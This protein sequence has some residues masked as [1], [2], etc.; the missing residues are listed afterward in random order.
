MTPRPAGTEPM[1][2]S[3][4]CGHR[5]VTTGTYAV[6]GT[7]LWT[8]YWQALGFSGVV[9]VPRSASTSLEIGELHSVVTNV[10]SG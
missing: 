1:A 4:D 9:Y 3:P 10:T 6:T 5:Y 7:A 2:E 8:V